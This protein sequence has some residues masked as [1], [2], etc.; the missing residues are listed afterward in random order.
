MRRALALLLVVVAA[1]SPQDSGTG[2]E[3]GAFYRCPMHTWITAD[4]PDKCT[5]CGMDLVSVSASDASSGKAQGIVTLMPATSQIIGVATTPARE[6]PVEKTVRLSGV[7]EDD[8]SKHTIISAFFD[9]RIEKVFVDH[10]GESVAKDQPLTQIYSPELLY[11]VREFQSA[12]RSGQKDPMSGVDGQRLIQFG[13]APSEVERLAAR[14][15]GSYGIDLRSPMDGTLVTRNVYPGKYVKSGDVLF[16]IADYNVMWFHANIYEQDLNWVKLGATATI[17]TPA[18][19]GREFAGKITLIDPTFDP[20]TRS[21]RVRIEVPN[22][23]EEATGALARPLPHRAYGEAV[24]TATTPDTLVVPR[25]AVL[26]TGNRVVAYVEKGVG[27]F[28]RRDVRVGRRGDTTVEVLSG[29]SPGENVVTQGNLMIDAEEQMANPEPAGAVD[30]P[31]DPAPTKDNA[32]TARLDALSAAADAL[33]RD[34][35]SAFNGGGSA[36]G[37]AKP[38]ADLA[39]A[40]AAFHAAVAPA[41]DEVLRNPGNFKVY[42]CPMADSAFPGAPQTMRWIQRAGPLRNPWLGQ[43]MLECGE[44]VRP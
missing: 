25:A 4:K 10:V 15:N 17:S 13:L 6:G 28:E 18:A 11:V 37:L 24:I 21:T 35:L 3:T 44:E 8:D 29:I 27:D 31:K 1:C 33:S 2:G 19:P 7:I 39:E 40:R 26:D 12:L 42:E 16:E 5:I 20:E 30:A 32:D 41:V 36:W 14:Q 43:K 23:V 34:D 38:A 9:G 22:P